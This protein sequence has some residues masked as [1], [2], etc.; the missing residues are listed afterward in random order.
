MEV[1]HPRCAGIDI[2]KTDAKVCVRILPEGRARP[3]VKTTT[4]K[5]MT[6]DIIRLGHTLVDQDVDYVVL[7]ATGDY[8]KPFYYLL[9]EAGLNVGLVNPQHVRNLPG[10]KTDV[11]DAAW[12]ADLG[13]HGLIRESFV[14]PQPVARLRDLVRTRTIVTRLRSQ[15][16]QRIDDVL[17]DAGIKLSNAAT[18]ILGMSGRAMLTALING[19]HDP[20]VLADLAIGRMR[21]KLPLLAQALNGRFDPNH[22]GVLIRLHLNLI[23]EY[24][25]Q[26][27]MLDQ[28]ITH[29][30]NDFME[31][32]T[33]L[34]TIPGISTT[35][36]QQIIAEIGIDM[37]RF[38]T[39]A[40]LT[41][42]AGLAP[43]SN[44]SAGKVK[45]AKCRPG[46]RWLKGTLG[47]AA[48]AATRKDNTYFKAR[49]RRIRSRQG[50]AKALVATSR[51]LLVAIWHVLSTHQ[52]YEDPGG[53]F[54]TKLHP[55]RD[56]NHAV[57]R[58]TALGY[59]VTLTPIDDNEEAV[60]RRFS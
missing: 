6:A 51:A 49:H 48:L 26:I 5:A 54:F 25:K 58:L 27:T 55:Q 8:W 34:D 20:T 10:R 35:A 37:S 1:V 15:E 4:W 47:I 38:P 14:P 17:Q 33:L 60:D 24:D 2:S 53:D 29:A 3:V 13:A 28:H 9:S 32:A 52:P 11:G 31:A 50:K 44:E 36:A 40:H 12:L 18:N 57:R 56:I 42:W 39:P 43:G 45:S 23:T 7:E 30:M 59:H 41:S 22:H 46:N 19:E 16:A 21:S